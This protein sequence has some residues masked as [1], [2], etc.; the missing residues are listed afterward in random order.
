[1]SSTAQ[2]HHHQSFPKIEKKKKTGHTH[3]VLKK[4]IFFFKKNPDNK[5]IKEV[6]K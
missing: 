5:T 6:K 1:M 4:Y 3:R 2:Q